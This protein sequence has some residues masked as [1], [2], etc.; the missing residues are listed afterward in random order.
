M[1]AYADKR[2]HEE[3]QIMNLIAEKLIKQHPGLS[4]DAVVQVVEDAYHRFDEQPIRDFV[5]LLVERRAHEQLGDRATA[6]PE[7]FD[8][9]H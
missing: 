3:R 2:L 5:P 6:T 4:A 1:T 8:D 9:L 7:S